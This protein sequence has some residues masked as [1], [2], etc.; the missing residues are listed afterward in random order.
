MKQYTIEELKQEFKKLN[1]EF[2]NHLHLVGIR[3]KANK[4]NE[5]DDLIAVIDQSSISWYSC[6]TNPGQY[7]LL[8]L[9]NP[10]GAA[11]LK[12]GQYANCWK[13]GLHQGKYEALTQC[14]E[15]SVYRD[16]DK[17][18]LAEETLTIDKGLFGINIHRAN[19]NLVSKLIDKWSAGCQV[20]NNPQ[21]FNELLTKCKQSG[22]KQF[23]YTLLNEF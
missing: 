7:W 15:V 18:N 8:N 11:L 12:P 16:K 3:S 9:A 4:P 10:K 14:R 20:L 5:F 19:P 13:L 17:D 6:T 2:P 22:L 1:Y 21:Q 23:T